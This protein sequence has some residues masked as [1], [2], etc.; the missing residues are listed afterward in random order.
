VIAIMISAVVVPGT[1]ERWRHSEATEAGAELEHVNT[2]DRQQ[3]YA[4]LKQDHE[5]PENPDQR[6]KNKTKNKG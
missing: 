1:V 5:R 6:P 4:R 2:L 3:G